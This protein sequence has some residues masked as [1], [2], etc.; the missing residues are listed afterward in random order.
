MRGKSGA[1]KGMAG[2]VKKR[3]RRKGTRVTKPTK[4]STAVLMICGVPKEP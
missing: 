4:K 1:T 2:P 3:L